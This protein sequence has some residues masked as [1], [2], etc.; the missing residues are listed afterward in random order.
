[1]TPPAGSSQDL[2]RYG[3]R[4]FRFKFCPHLSSTAAWKPPSEPTRVA[5]SNQKENREE[6]GLCRPTH[7]SVLGILQ[8]QYRGALENGTGSPWSPRGGPIR[9]ELEPGLLQGLLSV[10]LRVL[11][12]PIPYCETVSMLINL[13]VLLSSCVKL[14]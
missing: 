10:G 12:S 9:E 8:P 2:P 11:M 6:K 1:M 7:V 3:H 13:C 14:R 4:A 5:P